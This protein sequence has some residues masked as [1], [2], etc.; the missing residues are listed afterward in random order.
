MTPFTSLLLPILLASVAV[1]IVSMLVHT[2]MPWHKSDH[3]NVPDD[4]A[5]MDAIRALKLPPNDYAVPNPRLP[6]GGKNPDFVAKFESGPAFHMTV[7]NPGKMN[8]GRYLGTWF[9]FTLLMATIA[10]WVTGTIVGPG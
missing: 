4:D 10:G 1:F 8:M 3:A 9:L 6:G 7:M 2:V 5:A